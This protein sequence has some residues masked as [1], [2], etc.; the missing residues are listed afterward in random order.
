MVLNANVGGFTKYDVLALAGGKSFQRG[1]GCI[2]AVGELEKDGETIYATVQ[3]ND[4]YEVEVHVGKEGLSGRCECPWGQEGNFCKHCVAVA[5]V[6]KYEQERGQ[7]LPRRLDLRS[8]LALLDHNDL[9]DVMVE[10][11]DHD[12]KLR[13]RLHR[14]VTGDQAKSGDF[15]YPRGRPLAP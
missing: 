11:A 6:Y 3:G 10:A 7:T 1:I 14:R 4:L 13:Q 5:L 9:V 8:Y 15:R 2:G 12:R